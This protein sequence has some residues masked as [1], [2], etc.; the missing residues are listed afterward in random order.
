MGKGD[1]VMA[2]MAGY[3]D[4]SKMNKIEIPKEVMAQAKAK[5]NAKYAAPP[6]IKPI[7][8]YESKDE[9]KT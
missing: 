8:K 2:S 1:G 7:P 6:T 4:M 3:K 5:A 9:K